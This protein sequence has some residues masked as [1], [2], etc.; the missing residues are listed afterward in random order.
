MRSMISAMTELSSLR[1][2]GLYDVSLI[3]STLLANASGAPSVVCL[4]LGYI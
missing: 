1:G 2:T 4:V 3:A